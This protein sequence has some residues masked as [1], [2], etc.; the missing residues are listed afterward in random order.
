MVCTP[1]PPPNLHRTHRAPT[2]PEAHSAAA[3]LL[4]PHGLEVLAACAVRLE[5]VLL[6]CLSGQEQWKLESAT[7]EAVSGAAEAVAARP[8]GAAS[9]PGSA[10][11]PRTSSLQSP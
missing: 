1:P 9:P 11:L 3:R 7:V 6:A 2:Q 10:A 5:F 4:H 8:G